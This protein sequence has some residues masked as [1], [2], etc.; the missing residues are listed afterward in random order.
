MSFLPLVSIVLAVKDEE[1]FVGDALD[2]ALSQTYAN[3]EVIVVDDGSRDGTRAIIEARMAHDGRVRLFSQPNRG[4]AAARNRAIALAT[5]EFV[6]PLDAD[7]LWDPTKI[8]Q[9]VERIVEAGAGTGVVYCWWVLIDAAGRL[10]DR[11][12][13]WRFEGRA[14]DTLL[15]V[16]YIGNASV[17]LFRRRL[18]NQVGGYDETFRIHDAEGSE[19]WDLAL[20]IAEDSHVAVVPRALVAYRRRR[21][22]MSTRLDKMWRSHARVVAAVRRRRTDVSLT[23]IRRSRNQFALHLAGVAFWS[24]EYFRA[25]AWGARALGSTV[26]FRILPHVV[27]L[28]WALLFSPDRT[29]SPI[30]TAGVPFGRWAIPKPLIPYDRIYETGR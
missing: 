16:N 14:A 11:S 26:S 28:F 3:I 21:D 10:L 13:E 4:V 25:A 17:P 5:G 2:S 24:R 7:D 9:Q 30:I 23:T 15:E 22:S 8:E 20:K 19:D 12:P 6:A 29:T 27:R 18:V 1:S